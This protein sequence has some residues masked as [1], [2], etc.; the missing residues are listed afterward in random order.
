MFEKL[1]NF[2]LNPLQKKKVK[3]LTD[4]KSGL[5]ASKVS[6][7]KALTRTNS[8]HNK[9]FKRVMFEDDVRERETKDNEKVNDM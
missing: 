7:E 8:V 6:Y 4:L 9:K 3:E 2:S 1:M 5:K